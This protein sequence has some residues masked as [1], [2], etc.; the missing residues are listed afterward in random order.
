MGFARSTAIST[1][2]RTAGALA[3]CR[4][5]PASW[6]VA[7][8]T[9]PAKYIAKARSRE[10]HPATQEWLPRLLRALTGRQKRVQNRR[11][12][13][14]IGLWQCMIFRPC[15]SHPLVLFPAYHSEKPTVACI[16]ES[17]SCA[18]LRAWLSLKHRLQPAAP[19]P[20]SSRSSATSMR[21]GTR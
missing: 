14:E 5:T 17:L 18:S 7:T 10:P 3:K 4:R 9:N 12:Y 8:I 2:R 19:N 15:W 1:I 6:M 16:E 13:A 11:K 21:D 20:G